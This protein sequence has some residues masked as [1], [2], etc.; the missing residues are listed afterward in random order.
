[1]ALQDLTQLTQS[2][3]ALNGS[4]ASLF[5]ANGVHGK[6]IEPHRYDFIITDA[7]QV[8]AVTERL[9]DE[10]YAQD[11]NFNIMPNDKAGA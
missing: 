4:F 5:D 11:R 6:D 7:R 2:I 1:M 8:I 3:I 10:R 9:Q